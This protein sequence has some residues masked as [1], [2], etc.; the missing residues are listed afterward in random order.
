MEVSA[1]GLSFTLPTCPVRLRVRS[2]RPTE[3]TATDHQ[4]AYSHIYFAF[5]VICA[6][7][8]EAKVTKR[9]GHAFWR[10]LNAD[11]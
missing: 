1:A 2:N 3:S 6:K 4:R 10:N 5:V 11:H 8:I 7:L 9:K